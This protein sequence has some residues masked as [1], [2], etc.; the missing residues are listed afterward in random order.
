MSRTVES[1]KSRSEF[2][3]GYKKAL[4][5]APGSWDQWVS[6]ATMFSAMRS[7]K[8]EMVKKGFTSRADRMIDPSAT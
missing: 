1:D 4:A 5:Q 8:A 3:L 6:E 7:A 2:W